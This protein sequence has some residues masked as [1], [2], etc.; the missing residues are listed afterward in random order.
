MNNFIGFFQNR[1][2][3]GITMIDDALQQV[4]NYAPKIV[5]AI[6]LLIVAWIVASIVRWLAKRGMEALKLQDK[7]DTPQDHTAGEKMVGTIADIAYWV[8][9]L[10]FVPMIFNA[11]G[12]DGG[13]IFAPIQGMLN[14]ILG[15]LPHLLAAGLILWLGMIVARIVKQLLNSLFDGL[16]INS[17]LTR[18]GV[19]Q[20][21]FGE[22]GVSNL[23]ATIVYALILIAV[24]SASLDALNIP[25]ISTPVKNVLNTTLGILPNIFGAAVIL[26]VAYF[27]GKLVSN[28]VTNILSG[29]GFNNIPAAL[30]LT[31]IPTTGE[32]TASS[33]VGNLTLIGIMLFALTQA[34]QTLQFAQL[35]DI[36]AELTRFGGQL[37]FGLVIFALGLFF[38][39]MASR[40]ILQ[41]GIGNAD[42]LAMVARIAI[43]V[44][45]GAMALSR[46]GVAENIVSL[47][48]GLILGS[49]AVAMAI[50]FGVGGIEPA[51]R[52]FQG[53]F[54]KQG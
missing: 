4:V 20:N 36:F 30:G 17:W 43:L 54:T 25:A 33:I 11:L 15:F 3:T 13:A 49:I 6:I 18:A 1:G 38:A 35:S 26:I 10:M 16:G 5:G 41:S 23:L 40:F 21:S 34:A 44:F 50:A 32:R 28:L 47:A 12:V 42:T 45:T 14:N 53:I 7:L 2:L 37:I 22:G 24:L 19:P 39:Q 8:V 29:I 48:F 52:Y 46:I 31:S 27:I 51:R 9:F